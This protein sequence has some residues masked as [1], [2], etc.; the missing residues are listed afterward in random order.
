MSRNQYSK[1]FNQVASVAGDDLEDVDGY[2]VHY[3]NP[4]GSKYDSWSPKNVFERAY[5]EVSEDE[6]SLLT[7]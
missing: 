3:S 6:K 7:A 5:R 2:H 1:Q 4:N